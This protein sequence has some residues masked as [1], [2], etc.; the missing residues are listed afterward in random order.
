VSGVFKNRYP[1]RTQRLVD[2]FNRVQVVY[3]GIVD[4]AAHQERD[5]TMSGDY[6]YAAQLRAE[7]IADEEFGVDFYALPQEKQF[8]IYQRGLNDFIENCYGQADAARAMSKE[9]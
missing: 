8:E 2:L 9:N 7:E 4:I 1:N 6:K 5:R 3:G